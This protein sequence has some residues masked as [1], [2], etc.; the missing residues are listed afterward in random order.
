MK[1]L[2]YSTSLHYL[3][4]H[5]ICSNYISGKAVGFKR[6]VL[7]K[8]E[9]IQIPSD[10]NW[11]CIFFFLEGK[12]EYAIDD[13]RAKE[14]ANEN[15]MIFVPKLTY[16]ICT[17]LEETTIIS[18]EFE[19]LINLCDKFALQ[20]L[21]PYCNLEGKERTECLP[22]HKPLKDFLDLLFYYLKI[23]ML[24]KHMHEVKQKEL[25]LLLRAFYTKEENAAFFYPIISKNMDF[26]SQVYNHYLKVKTVQ[27]LASLCNLS[28][29]TFNRLFSEN[30]RDAP[31]AWMQKQ[32]AKL[33]AN[34]LSNKEIA[35]SEIIDE[36]DFSSAAHLT[37]FCKKYL[38][39]T[40]SQYRK[41]AQSETAKR[42]EFVFQKEAN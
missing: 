18:H 32:K 20:S 40:P 17:A 19:K 14:Q 41:M 25:F 33:I 34:R 6:H 10:N 9:T 11:N 26:K 3:D 28:L 21:F 27:E 2:F 16:F 23:G 7:K 13:P 31:Y 42:V 36:F 38:E 37:L 4:E 35:L 12:V 15:E 29:A 1:N 24:C 22:I 39:M 30:F 5:I 8:D